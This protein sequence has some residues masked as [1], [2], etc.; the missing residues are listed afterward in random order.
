MFRSCQ[1]G[2][3]A[4]AVEKDQKEI[5]ITPDMI[6][7]GAVRLWELVGDDGVS[8]TQPLSEFKWLIG[9]CLS[10]AGLRIHESSTDQ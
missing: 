6:E 5:E 9:Q 3:Y 7:A 10:A 1:P 4:S 8:R 2:V